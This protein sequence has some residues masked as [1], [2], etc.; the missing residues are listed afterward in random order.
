M[1]VTQEQSP[2]SDS[3]SVAS[4]RPVT[5]TSNEEPPVDD[6]GVVTI[7]TALKDGTSGSFKKSFNTC[8]I[9]WVTE[10]ARLPRRR[11][12]VPWTLAGS[13]AL[14]AVNHWHVW[15]ALEHFLH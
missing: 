5:A 3:L 13:L 9:I 15:S 2:H 6:P 12:L 14:I 7:R 1:S 4:I 8:M 10:R 11:V